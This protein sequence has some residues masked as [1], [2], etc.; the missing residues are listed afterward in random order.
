VNLDAQL[1]HAKA[2][3][4][5]G[6]RITDLMAKRE[7]LTS[8]LGEVDEELSGLLANGQLDLPLNTS[9]RAAQKCSKCGQEGHTKRTCTN[10]AQGGE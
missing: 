1:A 6:K 5:N 4:G 8:A 3:I 10:T 9:N 2:V 7:E